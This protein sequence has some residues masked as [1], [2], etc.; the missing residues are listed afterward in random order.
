MQ[1]TLS[2]KNVSSTDEVSGS[3]GGE[4]HVDSLLR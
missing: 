4:Y 2:H 1:K 3:H